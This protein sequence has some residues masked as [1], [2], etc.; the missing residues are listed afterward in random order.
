M[1]DLNE[2]SIFHRVVREGSFTKAA[3][4]LNL[5][6]STVSER[7]ARL[8]ERLGVRLL[9]RTTRT[10]RVTDAG[11]RYFERAARIVAEAEEADAAA[12][13]SAHELRGSI[14]VCAPLVAAR[15]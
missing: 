15:A 6:K 10:L 1:F 5:P 3:A 12:A 7:V 14:H 2:I 11:R 9:E 8:E 13:E 4:T